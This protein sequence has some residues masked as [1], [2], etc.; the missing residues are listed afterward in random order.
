MK[1]DSKSISERVTNLLNKESVIGESIFNKL[2]SL[3]CHH[4]GCIAG[5]IIMQ[6]LLNIKV[7][8]L[9]WMKSDVDI[10]L[11]EKA[12]IG[13]FIDILTTE[14]YTFTK[15]NPESRATYARL[16]KYVSAIYSFTRPGKKNIQVMLC[17]VERASH[18]VNTFDILAAKILYRE[19]KNGDRRVGV[20]RTDGNEALK[21]CIARKLSISK[22]AS[23]NQSL[24][25]WIRT[26]ARLAKYKKRGFE[27]TDRAELATIVAHATKQSIKEY[28]PIYGTGT[29]EF[30]LDKI[31]IHL[32]PFLG[33]GQHF[34]VDVHS[35]K[36]APTLEIKT[37]PR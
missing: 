13:S 7:Y 36:S 16:T 10:W 5:S 6:A 20:I 29:E 33:K 34:Y 37:G 9:E 14:G 19:N 28:H 2:M 27:L 31:A 3:V 35:Y 25:E 21:Q 26:T 24:A 23:E 22:Y 30:N 15:L 18:V 32:L 17:K 11:P 8:D 12:T 1:N 4:K